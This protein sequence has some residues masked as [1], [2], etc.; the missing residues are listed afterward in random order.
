MQCFVDGANMQTYWGTT[1]VKNAT[2]TY[3]LYIEILPSLL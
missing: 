2:K 1:L 3:W